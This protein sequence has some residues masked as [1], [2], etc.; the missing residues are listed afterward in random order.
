MSDVSQVG[1]QTLPV[2]L[3]GTDSA[4][5]DLTLVGLLDCLGFVLK[6]DLDGKLGEMRGP[7]DGNPIADACPVAHRFPWNHEDTF[8]RPLPGETT[9]P[10]PA[11]YAWEESSERVQGTLVHDFI[12]RK[13]TVQYI[14]PELQLPW[15]ASARHGLAATVERSFA[16]AADRFF[17]I[18]GYGFGGAP[19]G[20]P[21]WQTINVTRIVFVGGQPGR[22]EPKPSGSSSG[23]GRSNAAGHIQR[24]YPCFQGVFHVLE[25]IEKPTEVYEDF[26]KN[27]T[28][29]IALGTDDDG[30]DILSRVIPTVSEETVEDE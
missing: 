24:A 27:V 8:T 6:A 22:L 26:A 30:L 3:G 12:K 20:T 29:T 25:R 7:V 5:Q 13:I 28:G 11:L 1:P 4:L 10:L 18:A 17:R 15:G 14:F 2:P 9:E 21:L 16:K 23:A 19:D